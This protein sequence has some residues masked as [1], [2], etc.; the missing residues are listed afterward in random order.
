M[1]LIFDLDHSK[2]DLPQL[3]EDSERND[4][5]NSQEGEENEEVEISNNEERES[6][7]ND[8][9]DE[10]ID[11]EDLLPLQVRVAMRGPNLHTTA[12]PLDKVSF[13][14]K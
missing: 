3:C 13:I 14:K 1:I 12:S 9:N 7:D 11:E 10:E 2:S 8:R 5:G 6:S 4:N